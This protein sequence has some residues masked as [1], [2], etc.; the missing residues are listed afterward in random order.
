VVVKL[1][2]YTHQ[3]G[4]KSSTRSLLRIAA[5]EDTEEK[6]WI[7]IRLD[8]SSSADA[9]SCVILNI[10]WK[11]IVRYLERPDT[12]DSVSSKCALSQRE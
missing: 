6:E 2:S 3:E 4:K 8:T 10:A 7:V 9:K 1:P 5:L 11:L 12:C